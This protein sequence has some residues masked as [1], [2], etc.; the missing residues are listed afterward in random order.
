MKLLIKGFLYSIKESD[1]KRFHDKISSKT[2][3]AKCFE[4]VASINSSGYGSFKIGPKKLN[5]NIKAHRFSY[6]IN[7]GEIPKDLMVLHSCDNRKCVNPEHLFLGTNSDNMKDMANKGRSTN[8]I[9]SARAKL[10]S[11]QVDKIRTM[12]ISKSY[13]NSQL[14]VLFNCSIGQ[15]SKIINFK[16]RKHS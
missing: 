5:Y 9:K 4:W 10:S 2:D 13:T 12:K 7:K 1:K 3:S 6:I 8:G 14:A 11:I 15:I 16:Q